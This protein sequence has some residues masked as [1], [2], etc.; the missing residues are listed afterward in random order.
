MTLPTEIYRDTLYE[1][2]WQM[3][4]I[5]LGKK[6]G[7][8]R[9]AVKWACI[10]LRVPLPPLGFWGARAAGRPPERQPLPQPMPGQPT[11]I[12]LKVVSEKFATRAT[13]APRVLNSRKQK[14]RRSLVERVFGVQPPKDDKLSAMPPVLPKGQLWHSALRPLK[15]LL[16]E[17][18]T[19]AV[20]MKR[21]YDWEQGH[22]GKKYPY[23]DGASHGWE[24]FNQNGRLLHL[25][26]RKSAVRLTL[27]TYHRGLIILN[28]IFHATQDRGF[29]VKV[30]E[31]WTRI[32]FVR[33]GAQVEMRL[34]ER[35]QAIDRERVG[36]FAKS[37]PIERH[38]TPTD[39]L[40]IFIKEQGPG[41]STLKDTP[42]SPLENQ[43]DK[44]LEAI[45]FRYQRSRIAVEEWR[46]RD[47]EFKE[48]EAKSEEERRLREEEK[49]RAE[50]EQKRRD[51]L[52]V[53][54]E[55][56]RKAE[57]LRLYLCELDRRIQEGEAP[58]AGYEEWRRWAESVVEDLDTPRIKKGP[59]WRPNRSP[60][61]DI[62]HTGQFNAVAEPNLEAPNDR[63]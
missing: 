4:M 7:I 16:E 22:P 17:Q 19:D 59:K 3:P 29:K 55:N 10:E 20:K 50:E 58:A 5:E 63:T 46:I 45:E 13:P 26:H 30:A 43:V 18:A 31:R 12:S 39:R 44:I 49:R 15:T 47:L 60:L 41:T 62:H 11:A 27:E 42:E 34:I 35:R 48:A 28:A 14:D 23:N 2:V 38:F 53:E 36:A 1:E 37:L 8:S 32:Y 21:R 24:Y 51:L 25:T 56:W 52:A 33:D 6:Y 9:A 40:E 61:C 57:S 54:V